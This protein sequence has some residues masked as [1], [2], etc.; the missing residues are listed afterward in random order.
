LLEK[1]ACLIFSLYLLI[2]IDFKF[3]SKGY[4][5]PF[6]SKILNFHL[7]LLDDLNGSYLEGALGIADN[8]ADSRIVKSFADLLKYVLLAVSTQ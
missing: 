3:P 8:I 5:V 2:I 4:S 6:Q 1:L 7:R